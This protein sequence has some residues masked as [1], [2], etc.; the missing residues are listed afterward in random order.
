MEG[1][2]AGADIPFVWAGPALALEEAAEKGTCP[3]PVVRECV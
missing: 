3:V 2:A 1:A